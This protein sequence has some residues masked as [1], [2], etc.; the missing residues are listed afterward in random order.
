MI[1]NI[2]NK[3]EHLTIEGINKIINIRS[4]L[5]FGLSKN[6]QIA[7]PNVNT[8]SRPIVDKQQIR[9]SNWILGFTDGEGCF[10]I[11]INKSKSTKSGFQVILRFKLTQS[12]RDSFLMESLVDYFN[13]GNYNPRLDMQACD[14]VVSKLSDINNKIIPFFNNYNLQSKKYL[15]FQNF[16][17]IVEIV[18]Q[19]GHF[20]DLGLEKI[21]KIKSGMNKNRNLK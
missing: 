4:A 11:L 16:Q 17:E 15:D 18:N 20:T 21:R 2:I 14:F 3:K 19:K 8:V 6:L 10:T 9:D 13:C 7:F 1:V 5:N 12:I